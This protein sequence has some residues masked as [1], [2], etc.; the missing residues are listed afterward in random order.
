MGPLLTRPIRV[1]DAGAGGPS[2]PSMSRDVTPE[3][4]RA[5]DVAVYTGRRM[6]LE[7]VPS[8][9]SSHGG[10]LAPALSANVLVLNKFYQAIRVVNV[11]RAFS[12]L[13]RDMAE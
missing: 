6:S 11:R 13:C 9:P 12:M 5:S 3:S 7:F 10:A 8:S 2:D 4:K 1:A